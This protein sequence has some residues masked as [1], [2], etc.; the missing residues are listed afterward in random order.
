MVLVTRLE[1]AVF[2]LHPVAKRNLVG[3]GVKHVH[4]AVQLVVDLPADHRR[5]A[6]IVLGH[7]THNSRRQL[8]IDR[9][10]VV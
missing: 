2:L 9:R 6:A 1:A 8:A 10:V 3:I 4:F 5:V 7:L